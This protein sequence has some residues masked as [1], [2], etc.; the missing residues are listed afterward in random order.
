MNVVTTR[1]S[2]LCKVITK[3][4]TPT[5][6]GYSFSDNGIVFLRVQNINGGKVNYDQQT[7]FIDEL[8]HKALSRSQILAGDILVSI[9]GTIGRAG[10][11]PDNAPPLNCNQAVAIVR[12]NED[13]FRPYLRHWL[14][15]N[16]AQS[17][18]IGATVTGTISNLSLTQIGNLQVPL[19]PLEEQKRIAE[20][21]DRA[22]E[23]R[24]KRR[25]AIAQLDN[26]TQAIFIEMFGDPITNPKRWEI[27]SIGS[28]L[29]DVTNGLTRRRKESDKGTDIVLRLRDIRA[30]WIDFS[31]VNRIS[32]VSKEL[33][34]YQVES[35]DLLF[36]RVNGNPD[37]VGRCA[38]FDGFTEPVYFNDH[39]MRV[40][41]DKSKI[42]G[43]FCVFVLNGERGKREIAS[44]RKTS[45]GQHT[46][47]QEGLSK[48]NIPLPPFGLQQEF[49]HR[50]EAVEKLKAAHRASLSELDALFA[51]L[52]H[53]AFRGEL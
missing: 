6:I 16:N 50:A 28:F 13:I 9:A 44:H 32:L 39:I 22:E 19:P 26:L 17:Q 27:C 3:G 35:G 23:L 15:S 53:R 8:T 52:Q 45:A 42:N 40:K 1:L 14:E 20:I 37:Y 51:S 10:I 47:N 11:V 34:R 48:I 4:T 24:S 43:Q 46:I 31:D 49:S 7:L 33:Q 2:N 38:I 29:S 12:T 36:I 18:M 30:G 41:T 5:S 25:E 21:L